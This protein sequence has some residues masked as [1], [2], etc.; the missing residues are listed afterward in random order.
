MT[1]IKL[2]GKNV[3]IFCC[4]RKAV[5]NEKKKKKRYLNKIAPS[6]CSKVFTPQLVSPSGAS[7]YVDIKL[8]E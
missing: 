6:S 7:V 1:L 4:F 3:T 2:W 5:L 8:K